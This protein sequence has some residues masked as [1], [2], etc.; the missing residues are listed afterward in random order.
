MDVWYGNQKQTF[1][2]SRVFIMWTGQSTHVNLASNSVDVE[3]LFS[4]WATRE[5]GG[6][7]REILERLSVVHAAGLFT[8]HAWSSVVGGF[9][10][11]RLCG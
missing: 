11:D 3:G 5:I 2:E 4:F 9:G 10:I 7:R 1:L 8:G 6:E